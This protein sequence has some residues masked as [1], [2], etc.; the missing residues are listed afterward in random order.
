MRQHDG[1]HL[2]RG[3]VLARSANDALLA[4]DEM[5]HSVRPTPDDVTGMKPAAAP[6]GFRGRIILEIV[7]K[8]TAPPLPAKR[9]LGPAL[10]A[11]FAVP[12]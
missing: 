11:L 10:V 6:D 12:A 4:I 3:D 2:R 1:L 5:Q 9:D 7:R 8:E